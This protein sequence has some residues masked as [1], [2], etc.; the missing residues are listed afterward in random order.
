MVR[1][2][3]V[4][5]VVVLRVR[6]SMLRIMPVPVPPVPVVVAVLG[7]R[8]GAHDPL[9]DVR[10]RERL[11]APQRAQAPL[12]DRGPEQRVPQVRH[13]KAPMDRLDQLFV[14]HPHHGAELGPLSQEP[15]VMGAIAE[16]G[17]VLEA[18]ADSLEERGIGDDQLEEAGV[19]E[20]KGG[21]DA[22]RQG[23][24]RTVVLGDSVVGALLP[25]VGFSRSVGSSVDR[26]TQQ[27]PVDRHRTGSP[28]L[29]PRP[30]RQLLRL[31]QQS[32]Q[33]FQISTIL[34]AH[35]ERDILAPIL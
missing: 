12:V 28:A 23:G 16:I 25:F 27:G 29:Q 19:V 26:R 18:R 32:Q 30:A 15:P 14:L 9:H 31:A 10:V 6:M 2:A 34:R 5:Q 7:H 33:G 20:E 8:G 13:P 35:V 24:K 17:V 22:R 3:I 21:F 4:L 1:I 11:Q